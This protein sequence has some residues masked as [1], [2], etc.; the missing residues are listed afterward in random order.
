MAYSFVLLM[1]MLMR[2][3]TRCRC[4]VQFFDVN[5]HTGIAMYGESHILMIRYFE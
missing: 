1:L 5:G 2:P 4:R 3:E